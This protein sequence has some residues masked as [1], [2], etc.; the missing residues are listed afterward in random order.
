MQALRGEVGLDTEVVELTGLDQQ[1]VGRLI[2]EVAGAEPGPATVG[3][4]R[5]RTKERACPST[6]DYG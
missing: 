1:E 4:V 5:A 2:A 3:Q 6:S